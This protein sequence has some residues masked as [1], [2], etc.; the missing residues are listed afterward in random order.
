MNVLKMSKIL[1]REH[2]VQVCIFH[3]ILMFLCTQWKFTCSFQH[4][5][6]SN[7][8]FRM[9]VSQQK[10]LIGYVISIYQVL[11]ICPGL[12]NTSGSAIR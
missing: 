9:Y 2:L 6:I 11:E 8:R 10:T 7:F 3:K 1:Y 5:V 12:Y 4:S